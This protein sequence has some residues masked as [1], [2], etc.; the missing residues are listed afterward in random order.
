MSIFDKNAAQWDGKQRRVQLAADVVD[1][2][3][4]YAQPEKGIK[5]ADFGTGTGLIM[6]G[7]SEYASEMTG[8][9]SS[10]GMLDVLR[11]KA[12]EAE[13]DNL[14]ALFFD[15][16]KD[17]F[18]AEA[19]DMVTSSMVLHHLDDP[20]L[21]F[22]KAHKALKKGGKLCVADLLET[23]TPFHD[24]PQEG[25]K[26]EGFTSGWM[27]KAL[28]KCGFSDV[29]THDAAVIEKE[30]EGKKLEFPVFLTVAVK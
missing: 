17:E 22:E 9:D 7:L 26:H 8:Y 6:L 29:Q 20:V 23:G 5:L 27:S 19:Y 24:K 14:K 3:I 30:R 2:V 11:S 10:E 16:E 21:F 18:P 13:L 12:S 25:V 1:A 15:I 28:E 4:K